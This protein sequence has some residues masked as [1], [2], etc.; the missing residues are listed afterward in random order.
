M[1]RFSVSSTWCKCD[2]LTA[3]IEPATQACPKLSA[4]SRCGR[5]RPDAPSDQGRAR[6][7]M[8]DGTHSLLEWVAMFSKSV[9]GLS[10]SL[11]TL[12]IPIILLAAACADDGEEGSTVATD[13]PTADNAEASPTP[14]GNSV[15]GAVVAYVTEA[16]LNGDTF[17]VTQPINCNAFPGVSEEEEPVGQICINFHNSNFSDTSG[18]I[19]VW[20]YGTEATWDLTL[21][22]QNL[23]WVVT[24]AKETRPEADEQ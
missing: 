19:E 14:L 6:T 16:G 22:L 24:G 15:I 10:V 20:A 3:E 23:S 13:T 8:A 5:G 21:E 9:R 17:E 4:N 1:G 2:P 12:A 11:L 7:R 18:V